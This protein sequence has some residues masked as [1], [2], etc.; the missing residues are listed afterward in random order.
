[1]SNFLGAEN[2]G[3]LSGGSGGG[4]ASGSSGTSGQTF[5][6]SGTSGMG[7][8]GTSGSSGTSGTSASSGTSGLTGSSGTSG[9]TGS[10][11]TSGLRGTSGTSGVSG[12]SGTSG[13]GTSGVSG[14][15]GTS[16]FTGTAG[17]SGVSAS[18]TLKTYTVV[19]NTENGSL[20]TVASATDPVGQNLIGASGWSFTVD[21]GTQ[22]TIG[23]PLGN[24][25]VG[26]YTNG[27]NGSNVL[28]RTFTGNTTGNYSM[29]QNSSY[30]S[31]TFYSLSPTLG[32]YATVGLATLTIFFFAKV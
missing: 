31:M 14:S 23:H 2:F 29:F 8:S 18:G 12:S 19:I 30:N 28:T 6:T 24:V 32:G 10:S 4:G 15:S 3:F 20:T 1:M 26:A 16:G 9:Q 27:V 5:G 22:F 21:S 11:G 25:V 7:T 17:T 13:M